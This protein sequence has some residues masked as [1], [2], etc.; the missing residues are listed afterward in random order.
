MAIKTN[1]NEAYITAADI[2]A[3]IN[4]DWENYF[5]IQQSLDLPADFMNDRIQLLP[6]AKGDY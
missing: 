6:V 3:S 1:D 2:P 5:S 4:D